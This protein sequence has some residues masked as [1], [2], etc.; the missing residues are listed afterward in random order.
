MGVI[1]ITGLVLGLASIYLEL[2]IVKS[3]PQLGW[4]VKK[5]AIV[6][7]VFSLALSVV[8]GGIFG[9]AGIVVMIAGICSTATTAPIYKFRATLESKNTEVQRRIGIARQ[10]KNDAIRTYTPVAK[11]VVFAAKVVTAPLW[12]PVKIG[13]KRAGR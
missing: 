4:A 10:A 12:L 9:A 5:F 2:K 1:L 8:L 13:N 7:V 6:G 3:I 11:G